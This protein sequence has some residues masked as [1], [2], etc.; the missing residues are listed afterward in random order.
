LTNRLR[1]LGLL[2]A[3]TCLVLLTACGDGA[4]PTRTPTPRATAAP[5]AQPT[6]VR[7]GISEP[8]PP[9]RDRDCGDFKTQPEAQ[10]FFESAG[11]PRLD[12]HGLDSDRDGIACETLP[13]S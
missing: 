1:G 12:P 9:E 5:T 11:G 8:I 13:R 7:Q 2:F 6:V 4:A 10:K 3:A